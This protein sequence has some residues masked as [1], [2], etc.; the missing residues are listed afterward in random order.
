MIRHRQDPGPD[1][2]SRQPCQHPLDPR[3]CMYVSD[4]TSSPHL[5]GTYIT[6]DIRA[7]ISNKLAEQKVQV[8]GRKRSGKRHDMEK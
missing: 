6:T 3:T 4:V 2:H 5:I 8:N 1:P 7:Y